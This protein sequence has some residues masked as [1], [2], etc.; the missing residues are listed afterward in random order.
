[1]SCSSVASGGIGVGAIVGCAAAVA[2]A[3]EPGVG[4]GSCW[5]QYKIDILANYQSST[6]LALLPPFGGAPCADGE[7]VR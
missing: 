1:M 7:T 4:L 6:A 5:T 3:G 2:T